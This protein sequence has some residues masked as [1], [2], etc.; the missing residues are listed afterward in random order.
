MFITVSFNSL[1][2][3]CVSNAPLYIH[4][5]PRSHLSLLKKASRFEFTALAQRKYSCL[6]LVMSALVGVSEALL[7][8]FPL[9]G[10]Y[11]G[12]C[13]STSAW[14]NLC[15]LSPSTQVTSVRP[16]IC[17]SPTVV[18]ALALRT[19]SDSLPCWPPQVPRLSLTHSL[20]CGGILGL[21][22]GM[23]TDPQ[24]LSV[25]PQY[26]TRRQLWCLLTKE[27]R[28]PPDCSIGRFYL[29][30]SVLWRTAL[31]QFQTTAYY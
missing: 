17:L 23:P 6:V 5:T 16:Y 30:N 4:P 8:E 14:N 28:L 11:M 3:V 9:F 12:S 29:T 22:C 20:S 18:L 2:L 13:C 31:G 10:E 27:L 24:L 7:Q 15:F 25:F 19:Y 1:L 21:T 26:G